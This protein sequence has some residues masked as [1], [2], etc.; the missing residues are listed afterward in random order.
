MS[1]SYKKISAFPGGNSFVHY[2]TT[3][4]RL[5]I[6]NSEG[7]L[8]CFNI[9]DDQQP[10]AIDIGENITSVCSDGKSLIVT[11]TEGQLELINLDTMESDGN[12]FRFELPLR[13][14]VF[15]NSGNR[16]VC[17]GDENK[18]VVID[19]GNGN[20]NKVTKV[21]LPDSVSG[22]SYNINAE[23]VVVSLSNGNCQVYSVVN[24]ELNLLH[25]LKDCIGMKVAE[26]MDKVDYNDEHHEELFSTKTEWTKDGKYLL[27]PDLNQIKLY[28]RDSNDWQI[29]KKIEVGSKII[30]FNL[31]QDNSHL[32]VLLLDKF[33][34]YDFKSNKL[35]EETSFDF[36][37]FYP[38]NLTW[39]KNHLFVGT[40]HG[41]SLIYKDIV[42]KQPQPNID[43]LFLQVESDL[44]EDDLGDPL[45]AKQDELEADEDIFSKK[46]KS[47]GDGYNLH[48]EDSLILDQDDDDEDLFGEEPIPERHSHKRFKSNGTHSNGIHTS[49]AIPKE[50]PI[51]PYSP[52][53]TP[54]ENSGSVDRRYLTMN[55]T[56]YAWCVKQQ[57]QQQNISV[58][59]FD[60]SQHR[61]YNFVDNVGY[62]L[63]SI[64]NDGILLCRSG[65]DEKSK[66]STTLYY[67]DHESELE[68]WEKKIPLLKDEYI[69]SVCI[70]QQDQD[71]SVITV[72]SN[73]GYVR[74]FNSA[75]LCINLIK[76][77][78]VVCLVSSTQGNLFMINQVMTNVFT[79]SLLSL[80]QDYRF[81][82]QNVDL[83]LRH[84]AAAGTPLIKG[85]FFNEYDD[86]CI[87]GGHDDTLLIL[88]QWRVENN[89]KW[90]PVL[91]CSQAVSNNG[92]ESRKHWKCWP[93]GLYDN[94]LNC[95][96][97]K[98]SQSQY[99]K[100]PLPLPIELDI[101]LP[102]IVKEEK[103]PKK[104]SDVLDDL[105]DDDE[106]K[107]DEDSDQIK[108]DNN[109]A[110]ENFVRSLTLGSLLTATLGDEL[111]NEEDKSTILEKV[112][113]LGMM[114][115]KS[116]LKLYAD[117][118]KEAQI[119]K[120][121]KVAKMIKKDKALHAAFRIAERMEY[122]QLA[123]R[124]QN[125][126]EQLMELDAD[127]DDE[128]DDL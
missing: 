111:I 106:D 64:N 62:D 29:S 86:P 110:E 82:Q 8:K 59:F 22:L 128:D 54:F 93:L 95:L 76:T 55:N 100:F 26:S 24:E 105:D 58:S 119:T 75:G 80:G 33:I 50:F 98:N 88:S 114:Y 85:I 125:R 28:D 67:R 11:N 103:K 36:D 42:K 74:F 45:L 34:I 79:Y 108:Q 66:R 109:D 104:K 14:A 3:I 99:P 84:S 118:C 35:I 7:V 65:Y 27:V 40:T 90:I 71:K 112:H 39:N 117:A 16:I 44:E 25:T 68:A 121:W 52:G 102:V 56:G 87:V 4:D 53:S 89:S 18:L 47:N 23:I 94:R 124:I 69:V 107:E 46:R 10:T 97:L 13:D 30:D 61:D 41:Q 17:G 2:N 122:L 96:I 51:K 48:Q 127:E 37:G 83:P 101:E 126:R 115:D 78:P 6:A 20:E 77:N 19:R 123:Q 116:L 60:R 113:E 70:S 32:A 120:A 57:H 12:L 43:N 63:A 38:L 72:G 21:P 1:S 49:A 9:Q 5:I 91:N 31:S 92:D 73:F 15:I 81:Y